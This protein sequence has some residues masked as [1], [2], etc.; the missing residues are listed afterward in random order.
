MIRIFILAFSMFGAVGN[1]HAETLKQTIDEQLVIGTDGTVTINRTDQILSGP[2]SLLY[3]KHDAA[4]KADTAVLKN[5]MEEQRKS[6]ALAY[7][8]TPG[9]ELKKSLAI[10][11][12]SKLQ[13]LK[14]SYSRQ[15][16]I[17][18]TAPI[19]VVA[20][21]QKEFRHNN[22]QDDRMFTLFYEQTLDGFVF[23]SSFLASLPGE[24]DFSS[25]TVTHISVPKGMRIANSAQLHGQRWVV[26]F[27]GENSLVSTLNV[28]PNGQTADLTR[29]VV[30]TERKPDRLL[31]PE[32]KKAAA[33]GLHEFETFAILIQD[34]QVTTPVIT[35]NLPGNLTPRTQ[36][37]NSTTNLSI[38]QA[39]NTL[40][41]VLGHTDYSGS[42]NH[43]FHVA[44]F[45]KHFQYPAGNSATSVKA[46]L[47]AGMDINTKATLGW[48]W[49]G[50]LDSCVL[51][52]FGTSASVTPSA[53]A[54]ARA[55]AS[56]TYSPAPWELNVV[57][58]NNNFTFWAGYIPVVLN[59]GVKIDAKAS[60][61]ASAVADLTASGNLA[62]TAGFSADWNGSWAF[63][64]IGSATATGSITGTA[65]GNIK[66]R[67]GVPAKLYVKVYDAAGPFIGVEPYIE[68][69]AT[70]K[71]TAS[72]SRTATKTGI[73]GK[74]GKIKG[75][76]ASKPVSQN[77][78][79]PQDPT[80]CSSSAPVQA[81]LS[82][83]LAAGV[84]G[85]YGILLNGWLADILS[86]N[87][88]YSNTFKV[89]EPVKVWCGSV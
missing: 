51:K 15:L 45:S 18:F 49:C 5:F 14:K 13:T 59:Y 66:A 83:E 20:T 56:A 33:N 1:L 86:L 39:D 57:D 46:D 64:P 19:T 50:W 16:D 77:P 37:N 88:E 24:Q 60:M 3:K 40:D 25:T 34:D 72:A 10:G 26:D 32:T 73:F 7:G 67:G 76:G 68:A 70:A 2:L 78:T 12:G 42:W 41:N 35:P 53:S 89:K 58:L 74:I 48:E 6:Y 54:K 65:Q 30:V 71:A 75:T 43:P 84:D 79:T 62:V 44:T 29:T 31:T 61:S 4:M 85:N 52:S 22:W 80:G 38:A 63:N 11:K 9:L 17:K 55:T 36:E 81:T 69:S 28:S 87:K 21:G 23:A 82:V 27:G 47:N 8:A